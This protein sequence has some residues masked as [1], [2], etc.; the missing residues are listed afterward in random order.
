MSAATQLTTNPVRAIL[1][2]TM[3][4][5][6]L[7]ALCNRCAANGGRLV[8][9]WATERLA[10]AELEYVLSVALQDADGMQVVEMLLD[11]AQ[12][13]YPDLSGIFM[14]AD[15]LQ[16]AA[17]DLVGVRATGGGEPVSYTHLT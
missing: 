14:A 15:R 13:E 7:L 1:R 9:L 5:D 6:E 17:F 8:S 4:R 3:P 10:G 2:S 12:P 16:R 11:S